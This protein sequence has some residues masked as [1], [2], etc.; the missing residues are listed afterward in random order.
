MPR[1]WTVVCLAII[2]IFIVVGVIAI[3]WAIR[4]QRRP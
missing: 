1:W 2:G 4:W 3:I